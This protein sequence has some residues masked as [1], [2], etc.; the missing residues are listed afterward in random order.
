VISFEEQLLAAYDDA[1]SGRL[2]DLGERTEVWA[3]PVGK[4]QV[5]ADTPSRLSSGVMM[6]AFGR[7]FPRWMQI[8]MA[9]Q[10]RTP[11]IR[12]LI[13]EPRTEPPPVCG[14]AVWRMVQKEVQR[15]NSERSL[16]WIHFHSQWGKER[17]N[18]LALRPD[19]TPHSF[20]VVKPDNASDLHDRLRSTASFRV[21][22]CTDAFCHEGWSV[23]Q[24][25]PLPRLHGPAKWNAKRIRRVAA[26]VPQALEGLLPRPDA[27]PGHWRPTHGDFVPWNL[28]EDASGQLWLLDWEDSGWGPP[29][30]DLLRYVV[31][32]HS[33]GWNNPSQIAKIVRKSLGTEPLEARLEAATFW[34]SHPNLQPGESHPTLTRRKA[35]DTARA[36][37]ELATFRALAVR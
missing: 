20:I 4:P 2:D 10:V 14:W 30:A 7:R 37:R 17:S 31:A 35:K 34:L 11:L 19:G 16:E 36:A 28:R 1:F 3:F 33:L 22:A 26:D 24:Y 9:M 32:Y 12:R 6:Y 25:E 5:F 8:A 13:A 29:L 27:I 18:M 15:R 23:R 21:T